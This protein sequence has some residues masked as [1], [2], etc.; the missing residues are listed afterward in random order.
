MVPEQ[1]APGLGK[2][3]RPVL[4]HND[5]IDRPGVGLEEAAEGPEQQVVAGAAGHHGCDAPVGRHGPGLGEGGH[6]PGPQQVGAGL[7]RVGLRRA[8]EPGLLRAGIAGPAPLQLEAQVLDLGEQPFVL[9]VLLVQAPVQRGL[10]PAR[11]FKLA[12]GGFQLAPEGVDPGERALV[13]GFEAGWVRRR[14]HARPQSCGL[15]G[16]ANFSRFFSITSGSCSGAR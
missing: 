15:E 5:P 1:P 8:L 12:A 6:Q 3:L 13:L 2:P 7:E 11:L 14:P 4:H 16:S 9:E 10:L